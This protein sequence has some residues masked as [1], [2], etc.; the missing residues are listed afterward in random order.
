MTLIEAIKIA[1]HNWKWLAIDK[2]G[3]IFAFKHKPV[4]DKTVWAPTKGAYNDIGPYTGT[5]IKWKKS[6]VNLKSLTL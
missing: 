1:R 2:N 6:L 3:Y 4:I 5:L